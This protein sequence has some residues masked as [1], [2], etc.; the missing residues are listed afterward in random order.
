MEC[1]NPSEAAERLTAIKKYFVDIGKASVLAETE[2]IENP[3]AYVAPRD[4]GDMPDKPADDA[5]AVALEKYDKDLTT[6]TRD[7]NALEAHRKVYESKLKRYREHRADQDKTVAALGTF[8][9]KDK[10]DQLL[11]HPSYVEKP[12]MSTAME[13]AWKQFASLESSGNCQ[14]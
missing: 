3:G 14:C 7:S 8:F 1:V 9:P 11:Q 4:L 6:W 10:F 13:L 2:V 12:L 5:D